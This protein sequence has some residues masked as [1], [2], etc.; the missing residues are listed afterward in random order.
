VSSS[1]TS[2]S[3]SPLGSSG[4]RRGGELLLLVDVDV[5]HVVNVD[6]E[7]DPRAPEGDD[8]RREQPLA[9]GVRV[10]LE[11]HARRPVELAHDH[12]LGAVD[13]ERPERGHDGQLTQV[14]L[15][16]DRV[17]EPLLALDLLVDVEAELG[18]ERRRVGHVALDA[19]LDRVLGLAQR[20]AQE[21]ELVLLV[22]VRDREQV[23]EDALERDVLAGAV[24]VVGDEQR[25]ERGRL[26]VE[27]VRHRHAPL[28]LAER[29][30]GTG[31][32]GRLRHQ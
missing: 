26:D 15:L 13:H 25:L 9:V 11:H 27:E 3:A 32:L 16:L 19:L 21:L 18:L 31:R 24:D 28:A 22:D 20:V 23:P 12:A 2:P 29:D 4:F 17:L 14:D 7:L 1:P 10:L 5:D 8:P 30:D 6:R